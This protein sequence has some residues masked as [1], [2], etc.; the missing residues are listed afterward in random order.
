MDTDLQVGMLVARRL[1]RLGTEDF[2]MRKHFATTSLQPRRNKRSTSRD[3]LRSPS[4]QRS[5]RNMEYHA[6]GYV[7]RIVALPGER[8]KTRS[9]SRLQFGT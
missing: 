5:H 9:E 8:R 6:E 3:S 7:V 4:M 1:E 2:M